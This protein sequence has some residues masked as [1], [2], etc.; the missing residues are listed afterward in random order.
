MSPE[1]IK[2]ADIALSLEEL[3]AEYVT[4][5]NKT[6]HYEGEIVRLKKDVEKLRTIIG[7]VYSNLAADGHGEGEN[8]MIMLRSGVGEGGI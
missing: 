5:K 2:T 8:T 7:A 1:E 3:T 4:L 6:F